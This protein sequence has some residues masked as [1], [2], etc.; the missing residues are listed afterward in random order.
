MHNALLLPALDA[1]SKVSR[2][3]GLAA[4]VL[5]DGNDSHVWSFSSVMEPGQEEDDKPV[6]TVPTFP[7]ANVIFSGLFCMVAMLSYVGGKW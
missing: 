6:H 4:T 3:L 7:R 1:A 5:T 2:A